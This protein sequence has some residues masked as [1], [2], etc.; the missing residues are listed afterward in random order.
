MMM[1][2]ISLS[3][4]FAPMLAATCPARCSQEHYREQYIYS[5]F[6]W[7]GSPKVDGIRCLKLG[8]QY[9]SR[10]LK[11]IP[12]KQIVARL[13]AMNLP[14]GVD[15]EL[16]TYST[17]HPGVMDPYNTVQSLVMSQ[18]KL[19][20]DFRYKV[21]DTFGHSRA[22]SERLVIL[23]RDLPEH[24]L[25]YVQ[26]NTLE[27]L[28]HYETA[29]LASG[30][31][32]V[33]LRQPE[34]PYKY[35]RSTLKEGFLVKL[36][37]FEDSEAIVIGFYELE[38]NCNVQERDELGLAKRSAELYGME[39][40]GVLGGLRVVDSRT[41]VEFCIGTGFNDYE[42]RRIWRNQDLFL[43]KLVKYKYQHVG[44]KDKPR[45]PVFLG[46]RNSIDL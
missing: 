1:N 20:V 27:E 19:D 7:I 4:K 35:G 25:S 45:S 22:Y 34:G 28:I 33:M 6:P 17:K 8:G 16:I 18:D 11:P 9:L 41:K 40:G 32:G 37:N 30:Y 14:D 43:G 13:H 24:T 46:F 10:K 5:R 3:Y 29:V 44:M 15:G 42:R 2:N 23:E 21:F 39:P 36:K 26:L 38:H 31:E 12:N